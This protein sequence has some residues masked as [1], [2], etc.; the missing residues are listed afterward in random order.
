MPFVQAEKARGFECQ[1]EVWEKSDFACDRTRVRDLLGLPESTQLED[2]AMRGG[3]LAQLIHRCTIPEE[4]V[5]MKR[6]FFHKSLSSEEVD[7]NYMYLREVLQSLGVTANAHPVDAKHWGPDL[8]DDSRVAALKKGDFDAT[9]N[10]FRWL[11]SFHDFLGAPMFYH[12]SD[13]RDAAI[14]ANPPLAVQRKAAAEK[15]EK[16][17]KEQALRDRRR[18]GIAGRAGAAAGVRPGTGP[19]AK[20]PIPRCGVKKTVELTGVG[21]MAAD[22]QRKSVGTRAVTDIADILKKGGERSER[23]KQQLAD[24]AGVQLQK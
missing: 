18:G 16:E 7:A 19:T 8:L 10:L 9:I 13:E 17:A 5:S 12:P 23:L 15:A 11:L 20:P 6:I 21:K 1:R 14:A 3:E 4:V 2:L 22:A 24:M